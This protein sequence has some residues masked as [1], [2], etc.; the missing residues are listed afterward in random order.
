MQI[1]FYLHGF[2]ERSN[3]DN[4]TEEYQAF[5]AVNLSPEAEEKEFEDARQYIFKINPA[6]LLGK[7]NNRF[8]LKTASQ[9]K[10]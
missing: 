1:F 7:F 8:S 2:V 6:C 4:N 3:S 10:G 9:S 5:Y